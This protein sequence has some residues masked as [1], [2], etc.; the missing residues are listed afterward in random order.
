MAFAS[1]RRPCNFGSVHSHTGNTEKAI[2]RKKKRKTRK[3]QQSQDHSRSR[4]HGLTSIEPRGRFAVPT[5]QTEHHVSISAAWQRAPEDHSLHSWTVMFRRL[6]AALPDA[7]FKPEPG[8]YLLARTPR[9]LCAV[10]VV[11]KCQ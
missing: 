4:F 8:C 10:S 1:Y 11:G 7:G 3:K 2:P 6:Y 9:F 5:Q